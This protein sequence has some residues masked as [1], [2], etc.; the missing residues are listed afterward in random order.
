MLDK[1]HSV[2]LFMNVECHLLG[3]KDGATCA[4]ERHPGNSLMLKSPK[5]G[6]L[7]FD[8]IKSMRA[9]LNVRVDGQT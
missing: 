3:E 5:P 6:Q 7:H 4:K 2:K 8:S 1:F 9:T